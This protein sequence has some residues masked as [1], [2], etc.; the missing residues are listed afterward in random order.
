MSKTA[1]ITG[2][3][4]F[5]GVNVASRLLK[6]GWRLSIYDNLSRPGTRSNLDW[7]K[8]F[9]SF[10]FV[11]G[12]LRQFKRL[13]SA[14]KST[15]GLN[16]VFHFAGQVAVTTSVVDPREDFEINALGTFNVLEALRLVSAK[17]ARKPALFFSSTNKVYGGMEDIRVVEKGGRYQY[18][19]FPKGIPEDR[20][21]DFHSPYGCSKGAADQY[22][23]D[24]CRIYGIPTVV[25]RQSCIYGYRQFGVEDQGWVAW[26]TIAA[27]L[28]K[29]ITIYGDG[30][31]VRDVLF[32]EDLADAYLQ[33]FKSIKRT[34][35]QVYNIGGGAGNQMSLRELL[36]FLERFL[37]RPIKTAKGPWRPGDQPVF[38]CDI[39]K[40]KREFGWA[41]KVG[42]EAGVRKL[43]RW[44]MENRRL[45]A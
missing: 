22:V 8:S 16:A 1:F 23:R 4:G 28:G 13:S 40:A 27:A 44:V 12:D 10:R 38:V 33:A 21:L 25:F 45:F 20:L 24:Y 36:A 7:L 32:I 14:L 19:D 26:F 34:A 9:G 15:K 41:P 39:S 2:G 35:G 29:K 3:A 11:K 5:I 37:G 6:D 17:Q 30:K 42:V 43:H 18:R 31:Q